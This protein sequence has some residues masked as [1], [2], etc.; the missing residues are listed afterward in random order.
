MAFFRPKGYHT[1]LDRVISHQPPRPQQCIT[2]IVQTR[3]RSTLHFQLS[4]YKGYVL[5]LNRI[6][7]WLIGSGVEAAARVSFE[8]RDMPREGGSAGSN[9][10][11]GDSDDRKL[12]AEDEQISLNEGIEGG[13]SGTTIHTT[14][15][16]IKI[17]KNLLHLSDDIQRDLR[18]ETKKW[19]RK[20][21][22][23]DEP[24]IQHATI[25]V[26]ARNG[27]QWLCE[28]E[29]RFWEPTKRQLT[30]YLRH[31]EKNVPAI[32]RTESN[33]VQ[34]WFGPLAIPSTEQQPRPETPSKEY[35]QV[36]YRL[37][38][39][40]DGDASTVVRACRNIFSRWMKF[41][42]LQDCRIADIE[43]GAGQI[44]FNVEGCVP[45][46]R[47]AWLVPPS[48]IFTSVTGVRDVEVKATRW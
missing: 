48:K 46:S 28:V 24:E 13:W 38:V 34:F 27:E 32:V 21:Q 29:C 9:P 8:T 40:F 26:L 39:K 30:Y 35:K 18:N 1:K 33:T 10:A 22:R 43:I 31:L 47:S 7:R 6:R 37:I 4:R 17:R 45:T 44:F 3:S 14:R 5:S 20:G 15:V 16:R 12:D 11:T 2:S 23:P 41:T 25:D 42:R 36:D 19:A